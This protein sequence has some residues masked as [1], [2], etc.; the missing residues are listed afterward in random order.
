[1][2]RPRGPKA[3][4]RATPLYR[5]RKAI[6]GS[7]P[8]TQPELAKLIDAALPT[9]K[10]LGNRP[11]S[12]TLLEKIRFATGCVWDASKK[13][14]LFDRSLLAG[15]QE[16]QERLVPATHDLVQEYRRILTRALD[17]HEEDLVSMR[18]WLDQLFRR[19]APEHL[20]Q[21]QQRYAFFIEECCRDFALGEPGDLFMAA[22]KACRP[23]LD[24]MLQDRLERL[25]REKTPEEIAEEFFR[26]LPPLLELANVR[27][28]GRHKDIRE[29]Y[30][31]LKAGRLGQQP[32][33]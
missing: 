4:Y 20:M 2:P 15:T 21:L 3:R 19:V 13:R 18:A 17:T 25:V 22:S 31:M 9:L 12:S 6:G 30:Q 5:L 26:W 29:A 27:F 23:T 16:A 32:P 11:M 10:W 28:G 33:S 1:M 7:L 24:G 8:I 14:W